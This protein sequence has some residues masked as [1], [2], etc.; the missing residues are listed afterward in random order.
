MSRGAP[1]HFTMLTEYAE[2]VT[3]VLVGGRWLEVE[4]GSFG[5]EQTLP[6]APG[7]EGYRF[8]DAETGQRV[9]GPAD[10]IMALRWGDRWE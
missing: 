9:C 7:V 1:V 5:I 3:A 4:R 6:F 10:A 2:H 8:H